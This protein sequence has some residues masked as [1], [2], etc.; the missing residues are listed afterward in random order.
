MRLVLFNPEIP[1]NTG[2]VARLCAAMR[3]PLHL[4]EPLGFSLADRY[5]KRAGL[6]YWPHVDLRVHPDMGHF[7]RETAPSRLVLSSARGGV[8]AHRFPFEPGDAIVLG[9]ETTGL[10]GEILGLSE[11]LV[12]IPIRGEVRSLN[13]STAAGILLHEALR[14]TGGLD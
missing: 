9:P 2:N 6:D 14:R 8:P 11:H 3:I 10:P 13:M 1:P 5:L 7:L 12:R 4:I